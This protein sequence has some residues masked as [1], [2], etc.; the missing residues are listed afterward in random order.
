MR[1]DSALDDPF[2]E[3][4]SGRLA[5]EALDASTL[6]AALAAARRASALEPTSWRHQFRLGIASWG[7]ERLQAVDRTLMLLPGFAPARFLAG[8]V[9]TARQAFGSALEAATLGAQAQTRDAE[10]DESPFPPIGLHWLNGLLVLREGHV[11]AAIMEFA[12]EIDDAQRDRIYADEFRVN[13]QVAAGFAH[14]AVEDAAGAAD[15]FRS[16]LATFPQNGRALIGLYQA[17]RR[18]SFAAES[19]QLLPQIHR[20]MA[21]LVSGRRVAEAALVRAA[22]QTATGNIEEACR[23]LHG[24]L[25][26]APPG[27][28]GWIIPID[29]SLASLRSAAAFQS[30]T[31]LLAARAA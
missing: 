25:E 3:W 26:A 9:F 17:L 12:K 4:V 28:T 7:E 20:N 18:T 21:E 15:A 10:S 31:A 5:L 24:L 27:Q 23:T 13:A 30:V 11:G 22:L 6:P 19:S 8:M 1:E 2:H 29:P 14:L 16:A